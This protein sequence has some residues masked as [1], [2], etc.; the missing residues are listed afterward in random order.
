[1][2]GF[3]KKFTQSL[4]GGIIPGEGLGLFWRVWACFSVFWKVWEGLG[5]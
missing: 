2:C 4:G 1:M 5:L 3:D